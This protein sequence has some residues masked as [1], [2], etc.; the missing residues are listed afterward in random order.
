MPD[1]V[2]PASLPDD[3]RIGR[4]AL[5]V[6]DLA[7]TKAFYRD[8][9][10]LEVLRSGEASVTMAVGDTTILVL[11]GPSPA[12]R[13]ETAAGLYHN[14]IR[15]PSRG[16]LGDAIG[17]LR[18]TEALEGAADHGV[19]E[20]VYCRDPEDNGLEIYRDRPREAWPVGE[21]GRVQFTTEPLDIDALTGAATGDRRLPPG[22]DLGHVHLEVT[23][24]PAFGTFFVDGLGL[25]IRAE[26]PGA[27]FV[28]AGE[29]HHHVGGNVWHRRSTPAGGASLAWFELVVPD[30]D[31]LQ[32]ARDRLG[33]K[34]YS[35][36]EP[37][38]WVGD[39]P[40]AGFATTNRDAIPLRL[41]TI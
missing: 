35:I 1:T 32:T 17:R 23:D 34:G 21:D 40:A 29:Y 24:L 5:N 22:S 41:R 27:T 18:D 30:V 15:V 7:V 8:V 33:T 4:S 31:A 3:T 14:A 11:Q 2:R 12:A 16:A 28:A 19:S 10:G 39:A 36:T 26:L 37:D 25:S 13:P 38:R 6:A 20:A 9:I